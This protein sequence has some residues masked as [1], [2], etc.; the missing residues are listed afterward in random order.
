MPGLVMLSRVVGVPGV[1]AYT[2]GAPGVIVTTQFDVACE[3]GP[4]LL[5]AS[6][7]C[8]LA[9]APTA[10]NDGMEMASAN[11]KRFARFMDVPNATRVPLT[12]CR[13][14]TRKVSFYFRFLR[15]SLTSLTRLSRLSEDGDSYLFTRDSSLVESIHQQ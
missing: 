1:V 8:A 9:T 13:S 15:D 11:A 10:I 2:V 6:A 5:E 3:A 4:P 12:R 14:V 7:T